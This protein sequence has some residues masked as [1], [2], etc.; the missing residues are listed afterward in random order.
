[1]RFTFTCNSLYIDGVEHQP[2]KGIKAT[3][4]DIAHHIKMMLGM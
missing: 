4:K 2:T 1:M 3:R